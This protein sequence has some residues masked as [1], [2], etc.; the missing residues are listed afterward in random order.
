MKFWRLDRPKCDDYRSAFANGALEHPYRLPEIKC[1]VC[2]GGNC[3][4]DRVLPYEC[5]VAW[6][7]RKFKD[8]KPV[9]LAEFNHLVKELQGSVSS[10]VRLPDSMIRPWCDLQPCFLDI[11]SKPTTDFLWCYSGSVSVSERV[12][13][14]FE[15]L[16]VADVAFAP[17]IMR[18]VGARPAKLPPPMPSTGEPEE[19]INEV[20]VRKFPKTGNRY[21]EL[22][23]L[24]KSKPPPSRIPTFICS[25]CGAKKVDWTSR[26][27]LMM[28]PSMWTGA[29]IFYIATTGYLLITANL[30]KHLLRLRPSNVDIQEFV[31]A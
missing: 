26:K 6:R 3:G 11:P 29:E 21:Y 23:V 19:I 4:D 17:V 20:S 25:V 7:T 8:P 12:K 14:L 22:I 10:T 1:K 24:A 30:R 13:N 28:R 15:E 18:K 16:K 9:S 27:P 2:G 5:P 31:S